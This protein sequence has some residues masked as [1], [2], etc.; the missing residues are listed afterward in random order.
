MAKPKGKSPK[1]ASNDPSFDIPVDSLHTPRSGSPLRAADGHNVDGWADEDIR[2]YNELLSERA[3]L[4]KEK[5]D[6]EQKSTR[7]QTQRALLD[8]NA[9]A[10]D[11]LFKTQL[12][13]EFKFTGPGKCCLDFVDACEDG[14]KKDD[15]P[16]KHE[17]CGR[18][19]TKGVSYLEMDTVKYYHARLLSEKSQ[20]MQSAL[21]KQRNVELERIKKDEEEEAAARLRRSAILDKVSRGTHASG[22]PNTNDNTALDGST[23]DLL[24]MAS[25]EFLLDPKNSAILEAAREN[26]HIVRKIRGRLDKIRHDVNAGRVSPADARVKLDQANSEMAEAER[27]NNEFRQ[28]ILDA[29][30]AMTQLHQPAVATASGHSSGSNAPAS[31]ITVLQNTLASTNTAACS[32]ALTVMKGFFSASDPRDVQTAIME[33]RGVLELSGPM[34]PVL[35]KSFKALEEMLSKPDAKGFAVDVTTGD[36]KT[37]AC[38]NVVDVMMNLRLKMQGGDSPAAAADPELNLDEDTVKANLECIKVEENAKKEMLK[39]AEKMTDDTLDN[40]ATALKKIKAETV[41]KSPIPPLS[42]I[43][44]DDVITDILLRRSLNALIAEATGGASLAQLSG[45][46]TSLVITTARNKPDKYLT[47]LSLAKDIINQSAGSAP[48]VLLEAVTKVEGSMAK[49]VT[50]HEEKQ[51]QIVLDSKNQASKALVKPPSNAP[52][53]K[54][55]PSVSYPHKPMVATKFLLA[56]THLDDREFRNYQQFFDTPRARDKRKLQ[57]RV[58]DYYHRN[59]EEGIWDMLYVLLNHQTSGQFCWA[60]LS[61]EKKAC[62]ENMQLANTDPEAKLIDTVLHLQE[63]GICPGRAAILIAQRITLL[64]RH[65]FQV[66]KSHTA[67]L[68]SLVAESESSNNQDW[69]RS[70]SFIVQAMTDLFAML[71]FLL[72]GDDPYDVPILAADLTSYLCTFVLGSMDATKA[73][74]NLGYIRTMVLN[75]LTEIDDTSSAFKRLQD[76]FSRFALMCKDSSRYRCSPD[77]TC[78]GRFCQYAN[79][80]LN[81]LVPAP[82]KVSKKENEED[83]EA[84]SR[85]SHLRLVI[86]GYWNVAKTVTPHLTCIAE[87]KDCA[88]PQ[89]DRDFAHE[90]QYLKDGISSNLKDLECIIDKGLNPPKSL[91]ATLETNAKILYERPVTWPGNQKRVAEFRSRVGTSEMVRMLSSE[92]SKATSEPS[93]RRIS[94]KQVPVNVPSIQNNVSNGDL[95]GM[96]L[97]KHPAE[98]STAQ[99]IEAP[100]TEKGKSP[101]PTQDHP[102]PVDDDSDQGKLKSWIMNDREIELKEQLLTFTDSV[103]AMHTF[104]SVTRPGIN[105]FALDGVAWQVETMLTAHVDMAYQI[106]KTQ[107]YKSLMSWI[108]YYY[109]RA[110]PMAINDQFKASAGDFASMDSATKAKA[111]DYLNKLSGKT[112]RKTGAQGPS[113][114]VHKTTVTIVPA[115]GQASG[116]SMSASGTSSV[117]RHAERAV[118]GVER[119]GREFIKE[120]ETNSSRRQR[121]AARRW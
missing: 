107:G 57:D 103:D 37:R 93:R 44:L 14:A 12:G 23:L 91:W 58:A 28:M 39:I 119:L 10:L 56:G 99:K 97:A 48:E 89:A 74:A 83:S 71:V 30:P 63:Q 20:R 76:I 8:E 51:K 18:A 11:G 27:K 25:R 84:V 4:E 34:S 7:H 21:R 104:A 94:L 95:E 72:L 85:D 69:M 87:D 13:G 61:V 75:V 17:I 3:K 45:K 81:S 40:V 5:N 102:D 73:E 96:E 43:V 65:D 114:K 59:L 100:A 118:A 19:K 68:R 38:N 90:I 22:Q 116:N 67:I 111:L 120:M 46:L 16:C 101:K 60:D 86:D 29:E 88:C 55:P 47:T 62:L 49:F 52:T 117:M 77:H 113:D 1:P 106:A 112:R 42:D 15:F 64:I 36:G 108:E 79:E 54:P 31:L 9:T 121:V 78:Q 98:A 80:K 92:L 26:E 109:E 105:K 24:P 41:V 35:R 6:L 66:A 70:F 33:L 110:T 2:T 50:A 53:K 82:L 32:Q 115:K